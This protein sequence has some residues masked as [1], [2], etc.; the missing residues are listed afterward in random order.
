MHLAGP[1]AE[2]AAAQD[3]PAP[4]VRITLD[5]SA[6]PKRREQR[7]R[8]RA[9]AETI[10]TRQMERDVARPA[11]QTQPKSA[12]AR[13]S[14]S[15]AAARDADDD[16]GPT[17]ARASSMGALRL[18]RLR[19]TSASAALQLVLRTCG[20][21][22]GPSTISSGAPERCRDAATVQ[23]PSPPPASPRW[24]RRALLPL[25]RASARRAHRR[26]ARRAPAHPRRARGRPAA[27]GGEGAGRRDGQRPR[28]RSSPPRLCATAPPSCSS[29]SITRRDRPFGQ[30]VRERV[31]RAA[32]RSSGPS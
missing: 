16:F 31:P 18:S 27:D 1:F 3:G 8:A 10:A 2:V 14:P 9:L 20:R 13:P 4:A 21:G 12:G 22:R 32:P 11:D 5:R 15:V 30:R 26:S 23:A 28:T 7:S 17:A 29:P 19:P 6:R 24:G 25:R